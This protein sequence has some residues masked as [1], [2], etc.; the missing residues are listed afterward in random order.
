MIKTKPQT[1]GRL[2]KKAGVNIQ[3]IYFYERNG[4]LPATER[5]DGGFRIYDD[6]ALQ[7]LRFIKK[8]QEIGFT[9]KEIVELLELRIDRKSSCAQVRHRA[10]DK[11]DLVQTK[12]NDLKKLEKT[13]KSLIGSCHSRENTSDCPILDSLE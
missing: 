4:I 12:L 8:A 1:I 3:T 5:T 2:A 6:Q 7:R 10:E 9:L 11:L 13:L